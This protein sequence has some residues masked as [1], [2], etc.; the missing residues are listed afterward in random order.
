MCPKA[1]LRDQAP[2]L[3]YQLL[4]QLEPSSNGMKEQVWKRGRF[5]S[6]PYG[7]DER[8]L[9]PQPW[10]GVR[11]GSQLGQAKETNKSPMGSGTENILS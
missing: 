5:S 10:K 6:H 3:Q 8:S 1:A 11:L 7:V 2:L 9:F 4:K